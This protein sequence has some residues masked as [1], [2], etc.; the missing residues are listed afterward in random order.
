M[1]PASG[2]PTA[3]KEA[4]LDDL[5][6]PDRIKADFIEVDAF[7]ALRR[8]FHPEANNK[9]IAV[10]IGTLDL[11]IVHLVVR[12]KSLRRLSPTCA[13]RASSTPPVRNSG[14]MTS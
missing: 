3:H 11:D 9:L 4:L 6:L 8:D 10:H 7:L 14:L 12:R 5:T 2:L 13:R 1:P